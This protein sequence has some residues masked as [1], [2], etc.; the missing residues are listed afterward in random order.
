MEMKA[1]PL[2]SNPKY[3]ALNKNG[4]YKKTRQH[5]KEPWA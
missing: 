5:I 3:K 1:Y 4:T 2:Q